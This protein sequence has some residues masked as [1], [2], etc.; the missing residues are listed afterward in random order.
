MPA[1]STASGTELHEDKRIKQ[2][3]RAASTAN[4]TLAT[5]GATIDGVTLSS[6][7]RVLL[8]NQ[9]TASQNG[10]YVWTG[11]A[12]A[13]TR[14]A[15]ADSADDFVYGFMTY[16][17]EGTANANTY[18]QFSQTASVTLGSTAI[19]F[20]SIA[21]GAVGVTSIALSMPG[22]F[23]VTGSPVTSSGTLAVS[24]VNQA[25]NSVAAGPASGGAGAWGFRSLAGADIPVMGASGV[26][27]AAGAVPDPGASAGSTRYLSEA[28]TWTVPAGTG[29]GGGGTSSGGGGSGA[30][31]PIM[32]IGPLTAA[33]S[34]LSFASIPQTGFRNLKVVLR[35]RSTTAATNT[36][37][38]ALQINGDTGNNYAYSSAI[39]SLSGTQRSVG[40]STAFMYLGYSP[41]TSALAGSAASYEVDIPGY[42]DSA[43]HK[44]ILARSAWEYSTATDSMFWGES[45]GSWRNIA[46]ISSLVFTVTGN[47]DVG[48]YACLYGEMDTAGVLLTPA[49]NLLFETTLTAAAT[50]IDTG[51]LSQAYRDLVVEMVVRG[52]TAADTTNVAMRF[53][54]DGGTNYHHI[55]LGANTGTTSPAPVTAANSAVIMLA[56]AANSL[57]TSP[58]PITLQI[59][60]YTGT[61][62]FKGFTSQGASVETSAA[63]GLTL[64]FSAGIWASQS[65]ITSILFTPGA[66]NFLAGTSVRVYGLPMSA[67]GAAVGT[68]TRVRLSGNQSI[69]TATA[70][71]ITWDT[72]DADADNQHYTSVANLTG[73]V[74]KVAA[75]RTLT[76]TSTVF[77]TELSVG[78]V[79]SVPGTAAEK[80]V[81]IAIASNTSLTVSTA[82]V[83]SASGQ[84]AARVNSAVVFRQPGFYTLE[85]NIY[86]AA[87]ST[88]AVTLA[89]YLNSLTTA[90]SG[91]AIAQRDPVAINASAGYDLVAQRQF[92]QWDFVE[93]VWTQN[94]GGSVN[95][96]ADDR[97]H[98]SVGA[99]PTVIVA[100]PYVNIQDQKSQNTG[101]G[102]FTT[103]ADRTRELTTVDSDT[104]GIAVLAAN[105]FTLPT[106]T[107]RYSISAPA[108][109]VA[110]HQAW[111]YNITDTAEVKRGTSEYASAADLAQT[112][113]WVTGKMRITGTKTFEVRHRCETTAATLGFGVPANFGTEVYTVAELWKEA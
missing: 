50:G 94:S 105:Q 68:G 95:V 17:R 55:R 67:G 100:V 102:T 84:T 74:A 35:V 2:P 25:Q 60:N 30:L 76:G 41:A 82:F 77:T 64:E 69:T 103:G 20:T 34:T 16:V 48:S 71:P 36:L 72:E 99:R 37:G 29:G 52:D 22:E 97:T 56:S 28:A 81:V 44:Q 21:S 51:T 9:S 4:V 61:A 54:G 93:V 3:V 92:Q 113:S 43:F 53:N 46:P 63:T 38:V 13:L 14:A 104:A 62:F 78:Q 111:L 59:P 27:H 24:K 15:D 10:I 83:N 101:G 58:T 7:D 6:G 96:L 73:T 42:S 79:I 11:A 85:A 49:S 12:S 107:Y 90:T 66:G 98:F 32:V 110:R 75:S 1:H 39:T 31:V 8:K 57:A 80:R 5:P 112:R 91:T 47:F 23:S 87:L 106:G 108:Y 18:W 45:A 70:T 89:Y 40:T 65:A 26:S 88:G 19:T 33:Q 86:S 109:T